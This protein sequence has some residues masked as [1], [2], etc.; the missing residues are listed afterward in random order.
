MNRRSSRAEKYD[1][2]HLGPAK[3]KILL[4][5]DSATGKTAV[6]QRF[7]SNRF[8]PAHKPT[9]AVDFSQTSITVGTQM[10][11]LALWNLAEKKE[12]TQQVNG[13]H[14]QGVHGAFIVVD[15]TQPHTVAKMLQWK[16]LIDETVAQVQFSKAT[17]DRLCEKYQVDSWFATSA[18]TN[19]NI[20]LAMKQ[21]VLS[22]L[23]GPYH[24]N[25][26]RVLTGGLSHAE[27]GPVIFAATVSDADV[28]ALTSE[29]EQL[30]K[31]DVTPTL[32][33]HEPQAFV[34]M[35]SGSGGS[36]GLVKRNSVKRG[37]LGSG[38]SPGAK[39]GVGSG[40]GNVRCVELDSFRT[41]CAAWR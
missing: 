6:T 10:V 34:T 39:R 11:R 26:Q 27:V 40:G 22:V 13:N 31:S 7:A 36:G 25:F 33:D 15:I 21:M 37:S 14:F 35:G 12:G 20:E 4:L 16:A 8:D 9:V 3:L 23:S 2:P 17:L 1:S 29:V 24:S 41:A 28:A 18:K 30:R 19:V 32:A 5:G 38:G